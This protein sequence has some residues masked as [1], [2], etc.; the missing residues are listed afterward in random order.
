MIGDS[1]RFCVEQDKEVVYDAEHFFDGYAADRDYALRC[2]T[3]A[4]DAG[5]SNVTMCDTNGATLPTQ[6][7]AAVA[8]VHAALGAHVTLGIHTHN[9]AEC[10]VANSVAAVEAGARIVQG[11]LNGY[12]E[13]CG[14]ANLVAIIP[15][16]E[17][18]LGYDCIGRERL[19]RLSQISHE[20]AEICNL[21]PDAHAA[22]VGRSAFAHKGGMHVAGMQADVRAFEHI[23]PAVVG[24]TRTVLVSEPCAATPPPPPASTVRSSD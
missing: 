6:V 11:T 22:Y 24:N 18:K 21:Q 12:G 23:D 3:T 17:I 15:S 13:R 4:A 14:N 9:D 5:A 8:D 19:A 7:A 2:L 10:A 1:V 16:L 20:A